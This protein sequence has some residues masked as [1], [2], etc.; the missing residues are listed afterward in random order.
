MTDSEFQDWL[1]AEV[2]SGR[3]TLRQR[4]DLIEQNRLFDAN[5]TEIER[6]FPHQGVGYVSGARK[7]GAT[8]QELLVE[9]QRSY[10]SRMVF[11]EPIGFDRY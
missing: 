11:F 6:Q 8:A 10:P 7:V 5:R 2:M 3:M 4:D 1:Q 9:A